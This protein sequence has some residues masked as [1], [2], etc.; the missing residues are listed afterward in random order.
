MKRQRL[1][2][3]VVR[4]TL[5]SSWSL[6]NTAAGHHNHHGII[7]MSEVGGRFA[8]TYLRIHGEKGLKNSQ[9]NDSVAGAM[10]DDR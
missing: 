6:T 4:A 3:C 8:R 2:S 9:T 7:I 5:S 1:Q 10:M